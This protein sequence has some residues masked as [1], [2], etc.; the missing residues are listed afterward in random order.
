MAPKRKQSGKATAVPK[1]KDADAHDL[2]LARQLQ[3]QERQTQRLTRELAAAKKAIAALRKQRDGKPTDTDEEEAEMDVEIV[4]ARSAPAGK[5]GGRTRGRR[6]MCGCCGSWGPIRSSTR[7]A[8]TQ[9]QHHGVGGILRTRT[10]SRQ[11]ACIRGH[12]SAPHM[13]HPE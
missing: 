10:F 7:G 13:A 5:K 3:E 6:G 4:G 1:S 8:I 12:G 9:R 2:A 11:Y